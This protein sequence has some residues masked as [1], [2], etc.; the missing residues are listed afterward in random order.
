VNVD[1]KRLG[2]IKDEAHSRVKL[3]S[4]TTGNRPTLLKCSNE[5]VILYGLRFRDIKR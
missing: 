1:M 3:R 4:L 5:S 2:L